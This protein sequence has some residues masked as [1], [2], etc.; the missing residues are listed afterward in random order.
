MDGPFLGIC[1]QWM[2][3]PVEGTS[4]KVLD[5][6]RREI[7]FPNFFMTKSEHALTLC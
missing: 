1:W 5:F 7:H 6:L 2:C 4:S 3:F